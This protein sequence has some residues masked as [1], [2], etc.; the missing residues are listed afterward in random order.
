[1]E[2]TRRAAR[3][4]AAALALAACASPAP[5]GPAWTPALAAE[6]D[7]LAAALEATP[8]ARGSELAVH[9]AFGGAA[10]LDLYVTD[11]LQETVYFANTPTRAGGRLLT[12]VRCESAPPH[13]RG[14]TPGSDPGVAAATETVRFAEP[15]PGRYRV[16][17]DFMRRCDPDARL[18]PWVVA[19][20]ARGERR[21]LR[22]LAEWGPQ[23]GVFAPRVDEFVLP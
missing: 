9:L 5:P 1:V 3:L 12:D 7:A 2:H 10:D 20:D 13:R 16:G 14:A 21:L 22:G 11:P 8:V 6:A 17:V 23:G 18:A 19:V 15:L 4:W